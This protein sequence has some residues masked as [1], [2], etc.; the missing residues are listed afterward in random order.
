MR[1]STYCCATVGVHV[2]IAWLMSNVFVMILRQTIGRRGGEGERGSTGRFGAPREYVLPVPRVGETS[3][4]VL[5]FETRQ[6]RSHDIWGDV[7]RISITRCCDARLLRPFFPTYVDGSFLSL[8]DHCW[9]PF[10][11]LFVFGFENFL[12]MPICSERQEESGLLKGC[13]THFLN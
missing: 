8:H 9:S 11:R 7:C 10:I 13:R 5:S 6:P 12:H 1:S 4:C 2:F 3:G